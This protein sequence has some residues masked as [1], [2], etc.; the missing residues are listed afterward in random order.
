M[1]G[2]SSNAQQCFIDF[3]NLNAEYKVT[4]SPTV[5][6]T[7]SKHTTDIRKEKFALLKQ[8]ED[9]NNGT[10]YIY[11]HVLESKQKDTIYS[12][13]KYP[14]T[15]LVVCL[16]IKERVGNRAVIRMLT[17]N[18][19][20]IY[21]I[22]VAIESDD[23]NFVRQFAE[24]YKMRPVIDLLQGLFRSALVGSLGADKYSI[25]VLSRQMVF[26]LFEVQ[27]KEIC[28]AESKGRIY[29]RITGITV[30]SGLGIIVTSLLIGLALLLLGR[31]HADSKLN[32]YNGL[33]RMLRKERRF[34]GIENE[35]G[36]LAHVGLTGITETELYL[37]PATANDLIQA[38]DDRKVI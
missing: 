27:E 8:R 17:S 13:G 11:K 34:T 38:L 31:D 15:D 33:S 23:E 3:R 4:N 21:V 37:G 6:I 12:C 25:H 26:G 16:A 29:T 5:N 28:R 2:Y 22:E 14:K 9:F 24:E 36:K 10:L 30:L 7:Y 19:S 35:Q 20:S 1:S 18:T 32:T